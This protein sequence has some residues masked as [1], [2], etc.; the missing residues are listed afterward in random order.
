MFRLA[1]RF[2]LLAFAFT[3]HSALG[4]GNQQPLSTSL[5][6]LLGAWEAIPRPGQG[7]GYFSFSSEVGGRVIVR[8]NHAEYPASEG[9]PAGIHDDLMMIYVEGS[10]A[11]CRATYVDTEGHVIR[12]TADISVDSRVTFLSEG[13]AN[14]PRY[15]LSYT[16]LPDGTL[17]G[18][19][20]GTAP[21]KPDTFV[22]YFE[23]SAKVRGSSGAR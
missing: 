15:R 13:T 20:E 12:Y 14:E 3:S 2:A 19:F 23:W 5:Q 18:K 10:P 16:R 4:Q 11:V 7:T 17:G 9:R 21:A 8:K 22:T 6:F 1:A